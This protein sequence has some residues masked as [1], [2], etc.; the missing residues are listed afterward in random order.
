MATA[1]ETFA[2]IK[3]D[4]WRRATTTLQADRL[5]RIASVREVD[6]RSDVTELVAPPYHPQALIDREHFKA[7]YEQWLD[8]AMLDSLPTSMREHDSYK[9]IIAM[10]KRVVP[11]IAAEL[12]RRPGFIFLALEDLTG[13]DPVDGASMGNLRATTDAWLTWL[14][15]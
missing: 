4:K 1:F 6:S 13:A 2:P 12:R 5:Y 3:R 11:L 15:S 9:A 14:R 10:G 8:D 7:L